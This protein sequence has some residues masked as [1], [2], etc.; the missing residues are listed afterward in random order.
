M[1]LR[2]LI[3]NDDGI[4]APGIQALARAAVDR[5]LDVVVAAPL[6]EASG[7]S[8]AMSAL[9]QDGQ[10][11]V[12][13]HPLP[14]LAGV[15]AF[16]VGGS[17]GFIALIAVH[18]AFGPPPSVLLSGINRGA[19]AGRAVLH[20][21]TVGA[22][23]TAAAN[24]C[25][26]LA[27][28]LDVLS[29]GEATAVSGGAAVAAAARVRDAERNWATAAHVALDL[30]P[31]LTAG[32]VESVLNVNSPDVPLERLRGVRR[33]GLATFG[34]VQMTVA[35]SGHGFVRTALEEPGQ[36]VQPGTD[37]AW[38]A[39]GYATVTAVRAVTEVSDV[40]LSGLDGD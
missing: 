23:F 26:A 33:A 20:S 7:T 14:E 37:L 28:S 38:L 6:E 40:N 19:N 35:E 13:E 11:V 9:E 18:G 1:T 5:G 16:G 12:R 34:Q 22:A 29:V 31:R 17:P 2:V 21:G 39:D 8:A 36:S 10:V 25:R 24:G 32:P 27:V 4:A 30:L 3:T 15:P